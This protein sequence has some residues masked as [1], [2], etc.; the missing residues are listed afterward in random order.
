MQNR[1][2]SMD[3]LRTLAILFVL[4]AH[5]AL[6]AGDPVYVRAFGLFGFGVDLFFVLSGWLLGGQLFKE[7]ARTGRV[8]IRTFWVRRWMR[9]LPAYYAVLAVLILQRFLTKENPEFPWQ[10]LIFLQNYQVPLTFFPISWSL[11]VE[12]QFYLVIAPFVAWRVRH[13]PQY[14]LALLVIL[15]LL[16]AVLRLLGLY[17]HPDQTH[18][19]LDCC[20]MGVLL[21]Y[22]KRHFSS[23]WQQLARYAPAVGLF[24]MLVILAVFAGKFFPESGIRNP[25]KL[26]LAFIF[27]S[28]VVVANI[29]SRYRDWLRMPAAY[30]LATRSYGMYLLHPE[31]LAVLKR[32]G[33]D[34]L[35]LALHFAL[36]VAGSA[37][38]AEILYRLVEKPVMNLRER[39]SWARAQ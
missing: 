15:L 20:I 28:W 11:C 34:Q 35:P 36:V 13:N 1:Y 30:Y 21:A 25:D 9:T 19:R 5:T 16:P 8:D 2:Q 10:H 37:A 7:A 23:V 33:V 3:T 12:E 31:V 29:E 39:F 27:G 18:V 14:T 26:S 6:S 17:E 4:I 32:L 38:L 22:I 24:G